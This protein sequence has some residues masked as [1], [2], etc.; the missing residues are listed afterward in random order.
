MLKPTHGRQQLQ[1]AQASW[2]IQKDFWLEG[3]TR[4][5]TSCLIPGLQIQKVKGKVRHQ[6][7]K[8]CGGVRVISRRCQQFVLS[9]PKWYD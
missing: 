5:T 4:V 8:T 7:M 9:S 1:A 2:I 3:D 6:A